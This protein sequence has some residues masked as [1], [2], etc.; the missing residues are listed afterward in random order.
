M[1][2]R[3]GDDLVLT[4]AAVLLRVRLP[5]EGLP[6]AHAA[7]LLQRDDVGAG[8]ECVLHHRRDAV[9]HRTDVDAE[10]LNHRP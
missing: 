10:V 3:P 7:E 8:A 5:A 2:K 1:T 6:V 4:E 9:L